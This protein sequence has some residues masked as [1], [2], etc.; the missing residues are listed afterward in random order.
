MPVV[1]RIPLTEEQIQV[2]LR[3][4]VINRSHGDTVLHRAARLGYA[5]SDILM[6]S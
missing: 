6:V 2:T 5:V 1:D 3:N 4:W